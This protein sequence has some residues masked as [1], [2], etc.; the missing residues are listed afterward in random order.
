MLLIDNTACTVVKFGDFCH[1]NVSQILPCGTPCL[2]PLLSPPGVVTRS[3]SPHW[4]P[5]A[6]HS[7]L[8][9]SDPPRICRAEALTQSHSN[10]VL[11]WLLDL[12]SI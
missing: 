11:A 9:V 6:Q 4:V 5:D 3:H 7:L 1:K 2:W 12:E 10:L 8:T